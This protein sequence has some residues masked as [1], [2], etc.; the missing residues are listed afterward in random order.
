MTRTSQ[1]PRGVLEK[2]ILGFDGRQFPDELRD[3]LAARIGRRS[4]FSQELWQRRGGIT[5]AHDRNLSR[6]GTAGLDRHRPGRGNTVFAARTFHAMGF[7]PRTRLAG[8]RSISGDASSMSP[9]RE[10]RAVGCNLDFAPMLDLH[11]QP[12]SP[13]TLGRSYGSEP[14]KVARLGIAF[15]N[16]RLPAKRVLACARTLSGPRRPDGSGAPRDL[17]VFRGQRIERP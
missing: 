8:R 1:V 9:A 12:N 2:F 17:P 7:A 15:A 6:R 4:Y 14:Q 10:L 11:T 13:V 5:I 16:A 3:L